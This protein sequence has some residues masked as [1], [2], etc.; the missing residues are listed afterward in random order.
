V[1]NSKKNVQIHVKPDKNGTSNHLLEIRDYVTGQKLK[2][3]P[4]QKSILDIAFSRDGKRL[5]AA[6]HNDY[7]NGIKVWNTE[8]WSVLKFIPTESQPMKLYAL[9]DPDLVAVQDV[10][11]TFRTLKVSTGKEAYRIWHTG[12]VDEFQFASAA[13]RIVTVQEGSI[14]LWDAAT[15]NEIA[16]H[17]SHGK[18]ASFSISPDGGMIAYLSES[19]KSTQRGGD[20]KPYHL[21]TG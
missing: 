19:K 16:H 21:E 2:E 13:N 10:L 20:Y 18:I 8:D 1:S 5:L 3:I 12:T 17:I 9:T 4:V 14:R 11:G 6:I 7:V 15:G